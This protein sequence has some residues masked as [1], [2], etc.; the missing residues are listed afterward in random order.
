MTLAQRIRERRYAK[1]WG[2]DELADRAHISRTALY[3][4]ERGRTGTPRAATLN[5]IA[6]ALDIPVEALVAAS[7][8][9]AP[10]AEPWELSL[11]RPEPPAWLE[12][13]ETP[14]TRYSPSQI[15]ELERKFHQIMRSPLADGL[16]RLVEN[17]H[18]MLPL[19]HYR[20]RA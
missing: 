20:T 19:V 7:F 14:P 5:R 18:Q 10:P 4:I 1:G 2:P 16:A 17:T 11:D 3:Q 12:P 8:E 9:P 13:E 6:Q 15:R